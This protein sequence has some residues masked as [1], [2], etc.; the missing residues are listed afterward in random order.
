MV[1]YKELSTREH[2]KLLNEFRT[3]P[4][5]TPECHRDSS[6]LFVN[7]DMILERIQKTSDLLPKT[8]L[9][10]NTAIDLL[11]SL[12][13]FIE[14]MRERYNE[15]QILAKEI[16]LKT[17]FGEETQRSRK[18]NKHLDEINDEDDACQLSP[19]DKFRIGSYLRH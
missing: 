14:D 5:D 11:K 1:C 7:W 2:T 13:V 10:L 18:K 3:D 17:M 9:T 8:G 15:V 16:S 4:V 12:G 6:I 19:R